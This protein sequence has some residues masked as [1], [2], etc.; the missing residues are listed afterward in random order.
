M[1]KGVLLGF[2]CFAA[3]AISDAFVKSLH[4][5]LPAYEAVFIGAVFGLVALP[6]IKKKDDRWHQVLTAR[7]PLLWWTRAACGAISN[8]ASSPLSPC[9]RWP[10]CLR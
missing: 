7:G 4:G 2:A 5:S 3:F 9:C 1:L 6:F 8:I 10:R